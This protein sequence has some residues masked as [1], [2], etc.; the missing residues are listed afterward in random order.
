MQEP[1]ADKSTDSDKMK[2]A[3]VRK[4]TAARLAAFQFTYSRQHT[5]QPFI[6]AVDGFRAQYLEPIMSQLQVKKMDEEHFISLASGVADQHAALD[7]YIKPRLKDSWSMD[8][9]AIH[10]L[11]LLRLGCLELKDMPHIPAKAVLSEY[12]AMADEFA[13][14][15]RFVNAVLDQLAREFRKVEMGNG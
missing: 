12:A 3:A 7:E 15:T 2:P 4:R 6:E 14:D 1:V 11:I 10:E 8:R 13:A 9:L 5:N